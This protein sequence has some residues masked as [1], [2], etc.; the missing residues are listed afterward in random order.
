MGER[1]RPQ[2]NQWVFYMK[3]SLLLLASGLPQLKIL[4]PS[5]LLRK[6]C[7]SYLDAYGPVLE[8]GFLLPSNSSRHFTSS[9]GKL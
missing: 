7:L 3:L 1:K 8:Q 5:I 4:R 6:P 9:Y 2:L